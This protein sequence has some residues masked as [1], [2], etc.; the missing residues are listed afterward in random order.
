MGVKI[1]TVFSVSLIVDR[2]FRARLV[3]FT[4]CCFYNDVIHT[5]YR[6]F[7]RV[8]HI[9]F[10][11]KI[12]K[13]RPIVHTEITQMDG[14]LYIGDNIINPCYITVPFVCSTDNDKSAILRGT[15]PNL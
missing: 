6:H 4:C 15:I 14:I 1:I 9:A 2:T 12:I 5:K 8:A 13:I 3:F 7:V 10:N 11:R